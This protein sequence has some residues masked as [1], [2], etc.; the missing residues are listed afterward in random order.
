MMNNFRNMV[1]ADEKI[2][3]ESIFGNSSSQFRD[4]LSWLK[5]RQAFEIFGKITG[6]WKDTG[7]FFKGKGKV[8]KKF[9]GTIFNKK[10]YLLLNEGNLGKENI[11]IGRRIIEI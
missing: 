7:E 4:M 1:N 5:E 6:T 9:D 11:L 3:E 2:A 10:L 8:L